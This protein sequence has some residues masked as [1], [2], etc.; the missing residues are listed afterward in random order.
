M[1]EWLVLISFHIFCEIFLNQNN[2]S[3]TS[4]IVS[5]IRARKKKNF[6]LV[7]FALKKAKFRRRFKT[8]TNVKAPWKLYTCR[9]NLVF[10]YLRYEFLGNSVIRSGSLLYFK[11]GFDAKS[12]ILHFALLLN[13]VVRKMV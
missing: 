13:L 3:I 4:S 9:I 1:K 7:S 12:F 5:I 8:K 10:I 2:F 11:L 6:C